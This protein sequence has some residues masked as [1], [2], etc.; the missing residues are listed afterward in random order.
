LVLKGVNQY[1]LSKVIFAVR[2]LHKTKCAAAWV[3]VYGN[4]APSNTAKQQQQQQF[5]VVGEK[6]LVVGGR[7][8]EGRRGA[9]TTFL[10]TLY[11][12]LIPSK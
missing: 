4:S 10:Y 8:G 3:Y 5:F 7:V 11:W 2:G 6:C 9:F 1:R 12:L